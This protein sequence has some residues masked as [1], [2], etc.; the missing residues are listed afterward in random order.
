MRIASLLFPT[1]LSLILIGLT[2][3]PAASNGGATSQPVDG[4]VTDPEL[5]T[6]VAPEYP[7]EA[8][9]AEL[10]AS[11]ILQAVIGRDG[12]VDPATIRCLHCSVRRRGEDPE[13][14]LHGWC[15]DFCDAASAAVARWRYKP[16]L[17]DGEPVEVYFTIVVQF[18][19]Q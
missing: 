10:E 19:L 15:G 4:K 17:K 3:S 2:L 18:E 8:R 11:T 5:E 12:R 13:E 6:K 9:D 16:G 14:V 1:S 7:P